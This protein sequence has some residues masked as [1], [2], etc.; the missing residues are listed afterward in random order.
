MYRSQKKQTVSILRTIAGAVE[1]YA[2]AESTKYFPDCA[3][4]LLSLT[5]FLGKC[6]PAYSIDKLQVLEQLLRGTTSFSQ[7]VFEQ[8]ASLLNAIHDDILS[9]PC[10]LK[11]AFM[12]YIAQMWPALESIWKAADD[13]PECEAAVIPIPYN[14]LVLNRIGEVQEAGVSYEGG[15]YPNYVPVRFYSNYSIEQEQP[16]AIFIHNPYDGSNNLSRIPEEYYSSKLC[17]QT[18]CLV[19]SSYGILNPRKNGI[20]THLAYPAYQHA[21]F[22]LSQSKDF[23]ESMIRQKFPAERILTVGSPK[24][25]HVINPIVPPVIPTEWR[26]KAQGRKVFLLNTHLSVLLQTYERFDLKKSPTT[27]WYGL[28]DLEHLVHDLLSRD[29]CCLLWRPHPLLEN[30]LESRGATYVL[31]A[32][33]SMKKEVLQSNHAIL[34]L[35][36]D[37]LP[38]F[39][40]SDAMFTAASS[41]VY[42]YI[43]TG[44][45]IYEFSGSE[46]A[47]Q[48]SEHEFRDLLISQEHFYYVDD[49]T[50]FFSNHTLADISHTRHTHRDSMRRFVDMVVAGRDPLRAARLEDI[51][52]AY[53]N[54]TE[55]CCGHLTYQTVKQHLLEQI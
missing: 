43:V 30:M 34:D 55:G 39:N 26:Q 24:I 7:E 48:T 18:D 37:Y 36:P 27:V 8:A 50:N 40:L 15:K 53:L 20:N 14:R 2:Q 12:P 46:R 51:K 41:L 49:F 4:A 28:M 19:Y 21:H 22:V 35:T 17:K 47:S 45:P 33:Q 1:Y 9:L 10:K 29:D 54:S 42:E 3:D 38:A 32:V 13:D 11:V 25:D 31:K 44:K 23:T 5:D 6:E 16:D 52:N